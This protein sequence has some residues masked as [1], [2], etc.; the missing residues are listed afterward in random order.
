MPFA[1]V[2][3]IYSNGKAFCGSMRFW[4]KLSINRWDHS[5]WKN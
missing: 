5:I 4:P 3:G 2:S 1:R